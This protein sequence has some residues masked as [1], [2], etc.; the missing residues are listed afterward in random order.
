MDQME[1]AIRAME[2][3]MDVP[4]PRR[5]IIL[6]MG[7]PIDFALAFYN[8]SHIVATREEAAHTDYRRLLAHESPTTTGATQMRRCGSLKGAPT[9]W[10][11][12]PLT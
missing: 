7:D 5:E 4:F 3:L 9:S 12:T 6:L 2:S 1:D 11:A 8:G 10:Q